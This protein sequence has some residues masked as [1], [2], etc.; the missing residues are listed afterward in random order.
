MFWCDNCNPD[1]SGTL[2]GRIQ[3]IETYVDAL[4]H[5]AYYSNRRK[6]DYRSLI[7]E[8]AQAKGLGKR[9][10]DEVVQEFFN[11]IILFR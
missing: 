5:V 8:I 11:G 7:R 6:S 4:N 10:N 9:V 3:M 2:Y 1:Q